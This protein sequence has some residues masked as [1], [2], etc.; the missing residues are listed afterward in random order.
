MGVRWETVAVEDVRGVGVGRK[1]KI[2]W[3]KGVVWEAVW[4]GKLV[5]MCFVYIA[6]WRLL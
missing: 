5:D 3:Q 2:R 4:G 6:V 1:A